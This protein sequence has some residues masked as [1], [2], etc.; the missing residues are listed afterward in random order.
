MD[1]A[2][3]TVGDEV[4]DGVGKEEDDEERQNNAEPSAVGERLVAPRATG[5]G[6]EDGDTRRLRLRGGDGRR[7]DTISELAAVV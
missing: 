1:G 5:D 2:T 6:L 4:V 3:L 7:L